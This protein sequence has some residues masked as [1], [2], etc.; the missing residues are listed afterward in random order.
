MGLY[1]Y[2]DGSLHSTLGKLKIKIPEIEII[3]VGVSGGIKKIW[4]SWGRSLNVFG[5]DILEQFYSQL[6]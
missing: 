3:D 6:T 5:L 2:T 4:R 1:K